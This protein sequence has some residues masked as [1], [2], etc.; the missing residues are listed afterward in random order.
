MAPIRCT[1]AAVVDLV[2]IDHRERS[3]NGHREPNPAEEGPTITEGIAHRRERHRSR[4]V[5]CRIEPL[6]AAKLT[7]KSPLTY[8]AHCD[9]RDRWTQKRT[10]GAD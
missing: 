9:C 6:L 3:Q 4:D 5:P 2:W 7:V 10:C 8:D 1:R